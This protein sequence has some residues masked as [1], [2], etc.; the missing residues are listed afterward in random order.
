MDGVQYRDFELQLDPGDKL[1]LYTDG[2]PEATRADNAMFGMERMLD[3]LNAHRA[4]T[5]QQI[6]EG[7]HASVNAFVGDAPQFDDLTMLCFERK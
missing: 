5:P 3:A 6:L 4:G 7:V 2:V 1:F